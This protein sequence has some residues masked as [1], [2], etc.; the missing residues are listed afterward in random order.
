MYA[1]S[2]PHPTLGRDK[3]VERVKN[4]YRKRKIYVHMKCCSLENFT[5][6]DGRL[7]VLPALD[8]KVEVVLVVFRAGDKIGCRLMV[9]S[10]VS[11]LL[12]DGPTARGL[13][14]V[15][16]SF[17]LQITKGSIVVINNTQVL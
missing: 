8:R 14:I 12:S 16:S 10:N 1:A 9:F 4:I 15:I 6:H 17:S 2:K 7:G 3:R 5:H 13:E 11:T